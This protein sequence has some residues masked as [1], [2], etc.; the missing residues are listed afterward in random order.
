MTLIRGLC[1][2]WRNMVHRQRVER[3]LDEEV[4]SYVDML[5]EEKIRAGAGPEEA[6]RAA[7]IE[8]GGIEQV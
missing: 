7:K 8:A 5:T 3:E 2:F 4:Q 6:R 1:T